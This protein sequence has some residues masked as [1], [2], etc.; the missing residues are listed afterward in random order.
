MGACTVH[1]ITRVTIKQ[2]AAQ[3]GVSTQTVS[4][5]LNDRPDVSPE[6][7][8]RV[9]QTIDRL[10]Y[11]PSAVARSLI[12]RRTHTIGVVGSS[13]EYFGPSTTLVGIEKEAAE[14]GFSVLLVLVHEPDTENVRPVLEDMLSRQVE[15]I[16]WAVPEIGNNH[17]WVDA[18]A[19]PTLPIVFLT[20]ATR[21]NL[22]SVTVDNRLGGRLATEHLLTSGYR[23]IGLIT[24]P[25]SWWEA[26]ERKL[27][28]EDALAAAGLVVNVRQVVNGD[29][30]AASGEQ[31]FTQMRE[32]FPEV[33]AIFASNDQMA[34]GV[35]HAAW[36]A[37]LHVPDD[38]AVVGF[39]DNPEA[40]Y[41]IPSLT[42]VRQQSAELGRTAVR[43]LNNLIQ[44][45]HQTGRVPEV[46]A[47]RLE[48]DLI[49]RKSSFAHE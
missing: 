49:N 22:P 42:T 11:K 27:G 40:L 44:E 43:M 34:Q 5:V 9:Q 10:A 26:R 15:G 31:A 48:P 1:S 6:T 24:G 29:W 4:R 39:D 13:L 8:T 45:G 36:T 32:Q 14:S 37:N 21:P 46:E 7:R 30:S 19:V 3:A 28:W 12:G 20:M 35:L 18:L 41:F 17:L 33:D 38:L 16:I 2:V 47:I 25:L 23:H